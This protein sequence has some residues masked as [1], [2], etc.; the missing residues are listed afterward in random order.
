LQI[1]IASTYLTCTIEVLY[2]NGK[3]NRIIV[4]IR[5]SSS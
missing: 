4:G 2:L 3:S 5:V 1:E